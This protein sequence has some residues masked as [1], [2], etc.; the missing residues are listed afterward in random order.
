MKYSISKIYQKCPYKNA[1]YI[2][3]PW[4]QPL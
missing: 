4:L 1:I 2:F 3:G